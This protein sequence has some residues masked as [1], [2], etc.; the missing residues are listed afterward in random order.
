MGPQSIQSPGRGRSTS[1]GELSL[2]REP[3]PFLSER[4]HGVC[5]L[6]VPL[7][8]TLHE[9]IVEPWPRPQG[10]VMGDERAWAG[11]M[12]LGASMQSATDSW[13]GLVT[14]LP[15]TLGFLAVKGSYVLSH[16]HRKVQ[17]IGCV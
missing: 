4:P 1:V 3:H 6:S 11:T 12:V 14:L 13:P 9:D 2:G 5:S 15:Q 8:A 7:A 10:G 17:M 16:S